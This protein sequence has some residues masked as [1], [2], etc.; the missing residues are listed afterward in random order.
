MKERGESSESMDPNSGV[1]VCRGEKGIEIASS[2][3]WSGRVVVVTIGFAFCHQGSSP[4]LSGK[5]V[6]VEVVGSCSP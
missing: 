6:K 2:Y 3:R 1:E 5:V 4:T